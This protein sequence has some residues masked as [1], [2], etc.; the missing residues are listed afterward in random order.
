MRIDTECPYDHKF[1]AERIKT[2][3]FD[4]LIPLQPSH[5]SSLLVRKK[6]KVAAEKITKR[7]V[8]KS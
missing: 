2:G 7:Y 3:Y 6:I 5:L 1:R 8:R 4:Y